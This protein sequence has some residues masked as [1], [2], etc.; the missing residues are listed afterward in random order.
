MAIFALN[1]PFGVLSQ[2]SNEGARAG[3]GSLSLGLPKDAY[4]IGR[5]DADSEGLLLLSDE[6]EM[7]GKLLNPQRPHGRTYWV[8]VEGTPT[9][10]QLRRLGQ[11]LDLRIQ[12]KA[13]R[14]RP[15]EVL[16]IAVPDGIPPR[17]PPIR[18]RNAIPTAW[19]QMVLHEGKNRQV[20][21]MTASVGMPTLRLIRAAWGPLVLQD[22]GLAPGE[23]RM[24]TER[25]RNQLLSA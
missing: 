13:F 19:I 7:N 6:R 9:D 20:R 12:G 23:V 5:L 16:S 11:P 21:R 2:F 10:E 14:T 8:Q 17:N 25:E 1:K 18:T 4:A 15:C 22:L 24:L 3:W